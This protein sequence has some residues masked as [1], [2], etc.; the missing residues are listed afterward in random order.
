MIFSKKLDDFARAPGIALDGQP[1]LVLVAPDGELLEV[2]KGE[3]TP[4][5]IEAVSVAVATYLQ[6]VTDAAAPSAPDQKD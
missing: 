5:S 3:A 6:R 2:F 4:E 1:T